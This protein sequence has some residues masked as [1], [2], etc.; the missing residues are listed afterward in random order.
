MKWKKIGDILILDNKFT[1]QSDTQLKELSDKHNV[2]TI[3]KVDH[4]YGTK[5]EDR[6]SV[7]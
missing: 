1:V 3:M 5:R 6:K 7:V 2:K 4:I